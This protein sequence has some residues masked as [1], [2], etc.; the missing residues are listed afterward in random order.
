MERPNPGQA[1]PM[2]R[3]VVVASSQQATSGQRPLL[4]PRAFDHSLSTSTAVMMVE[5][6]MEMMMV[7]RLEM[8]MVMVVMLMKMM[9]MPLDME[10]PQ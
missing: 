2:P 5:M 1:Q 4:S 8:M 7:N 6:M 10:L 3:I 9:A